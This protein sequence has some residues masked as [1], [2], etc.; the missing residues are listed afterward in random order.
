MIESLFRTLLNAAP[1]A[2]LLLL[3]GE[4]KGQTNCW[5][6]SPMLYA[7]QAVPAF[8]N[9]RGVPYRLRPLRVGWMPC[10]SLSVPLPLSLALRRKGLY[11]PS[12][13]R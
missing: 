6:L 11:K 12:L 13:P 4:K 9:G 5:H 7:R 8:E 3:L 10:D 1:V 2:G